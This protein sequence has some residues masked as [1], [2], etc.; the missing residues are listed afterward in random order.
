[1]TGFVERGLGHFAGQG[2]EVKRLMSDNAWSYTRNKS[3]AQLLAVGGVRHILIPYRRPQLNGKVERYQQTLKREWGLGQSYRSS[4]HRA[5]ALSHWLL[6][7][8]ER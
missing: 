7:Y 5:L 6:Y 1:V 4:E 3:L 2:I 8:N